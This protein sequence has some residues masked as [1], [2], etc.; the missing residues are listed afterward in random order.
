MLY[1]DNSKVINTEICNEM[2]NSILNYAMSVIVSRALPDVR[3]GLKQY[4]AEF[5]IHFMKTVLHLTRHTENV[6]IL[7]VLYSDAIT[8][9]VTHLFMMHS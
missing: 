6:L 7:S 9:T 2:E 3:D 4:T 5:Y 8:H 1:N